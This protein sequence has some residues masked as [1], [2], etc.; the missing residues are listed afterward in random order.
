MYRPHFG[1]T[2]HPF[3]NEVEPEDLFPA[4]ATKELEVRLTHLLEMRGIG[5]ITGDSGAQRQLVLCTG[6]NYFCALQGSAG[7]G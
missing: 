2:H 1:L 3:T 6:D 4:T 7:R 5:L